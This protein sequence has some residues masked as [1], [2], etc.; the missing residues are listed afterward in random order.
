MNRRRLIGEARFVKRSKKPIAA[1]ISGEDATG[2]ISP[3]SRGREPYHKQPRSRIAE[4]RHRLAPILL[5]G[6]A[7]NPFARDSL[8]PVD[9]ARAK[10]ARYNFVL[11]SC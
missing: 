7:A 10:P 6:E 1:P 5:I 4:A 11:Q 8:A 2:S 9:Q 3:V